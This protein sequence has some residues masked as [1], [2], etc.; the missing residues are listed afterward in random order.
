MNGSMSRI[1]GFLTDK[2]GRCP[3][4]MKTSL[5]LSAIAWALFTLQYLL[6]GRTDVVMA[7]GVAAIG[8]TMLWLAHLVAF[9]G[10]AT[11]ARAKKAAA[12]MPPARQPRV[13]IS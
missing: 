1:F 2:L 6:T 12:R 4:C 11:L 13:A 8:L 3:R 9:A 7:L 5:N 10:R